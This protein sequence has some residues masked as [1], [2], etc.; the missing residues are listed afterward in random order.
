M[1]AQAQVRH[2][3]VVDDDRAF[4]HAIAALLEKAGYATGQ[5]ADGV[6]ALAQ[7]RRGRST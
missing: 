7:L 6:D 5:A 2:V 1:T 4:R 3:L